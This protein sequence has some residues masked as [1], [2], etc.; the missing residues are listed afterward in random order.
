MKT[1]EQ[2]KTERHRALAKF[3]ECGCTAYKVKAAK[4]TAEIRDLEN[5]KVDG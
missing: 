3:N 1:L 2:L 5:K 4:L